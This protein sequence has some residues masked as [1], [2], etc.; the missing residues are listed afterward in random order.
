MSVPAQNVTDIFGAILAAF[1]SGSP[2][3]TIFGATL[4]IPEI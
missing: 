1:E 4:L 2:I 3:G